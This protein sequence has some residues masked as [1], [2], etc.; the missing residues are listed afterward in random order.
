MGR[1]VGPEVGHRI[2]ARARAA[3]LLEQRQL[4]QY[5]RLLEGAAG[6]HG[7]D[8]LALRGSCVCVCVWWGWGAPVSACAGVGLR[9]RGAKPVGGQ[10]RRCVH[11]SGAATPPFVV[12][13]RAS[14]VARHPALPPALPA[15][16]CAAGPWPAARAPGGGGVAAS[17]PIAGARPCSG[18]RSDG[19]GRTAAQRAPGAAR[20]RERVIDLLRGAGPCCLSKKAGVARCRLP[21]PHYSS[22]PLHRRRAVAALL[23][24]HPT[25]PPPAT[26]PA[27]A[28]SRTQSRPAATLAVN[29]GPQCAAAARRLPW[30][31]PPWRRRKNC[32]A[33]SRRRGCSC[34]RT[35]SRS[36]ARSCPSCSTRCAGG[37]AG[38]RGHRP[39]A[40]GC[41]AGSGRHLTRAAL[42]AQATGGEAGAPGGEG[43]AGA[44]EAGPSRRAL[45][46]KQ[47]LQRQR[48]QLT[49]NQLKKQ[50]KKLS[51]LFNQ[52]R[53]AAARRVRPA[54]RCATPPAASAARAP[55]RCL[56]RAG[57][58][59]CRRPAGRA[60][61]GGR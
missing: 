30:W 47:R 51:K 34:P 32:S 45:E 6:V 41:G 10:H 59:G 27:P 9:A 50:R 56:R 42:A 22:R 17:A 1:P 11:D 19:G 36:S 14:A 58:P 49:R 39:A 7:H 5:L 31:T 57:D 53:A 24:T 2:E 26:R 60:A 23:H 12:E 38:E 37:P 61:A 18:W 35:G 16:C 48:D 21:R 29:P 3:R 25:R 43:G 13:E 52:V 20:E 55:R 8:A 28:D 44:A 40:V 15:A 4:L 54:P 46:L 33:S